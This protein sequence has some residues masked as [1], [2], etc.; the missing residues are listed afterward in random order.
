[1]GQPA[2]KQRRATYAD[3]E[4]VPPN[5]VA[6]LIGGV[7]HVMPRPAPRH[8]QAETELAT[9]LVGAFGRG[10]GGP[11]GWRILVEP[12]LHFPDP[13]APGE[14]DA[15]VPDLAGWRRE[16]MPELPETAYFALAP[17]WICE[18]PSASTEDVDRHEK[19][20][21]YAREGVRQA[22]LVDPIARTLEIYALG[23][24]RRWGP[25]VVHRDAARVR[26]QPF[27]AIELDLSVLW[28]K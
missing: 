1:M 16:R 22:W 26:A 19:M 5:K 9:E 13:D 23:E 8:A 28:A 11:G 3:L 27:D 15:L 2:E 7:L 24:D 17:D 18:V 6:E 10:R 12:E 20:P 21:V 14:I 25:A 4:A